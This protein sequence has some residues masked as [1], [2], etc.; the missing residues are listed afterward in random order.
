MLHAVTSFPFYNSYVYLPPK[1]APIPPEIVSNPKFFPY[2]KNVQGALDGVH[3]KCCPSAIERALARNRKGE[4]TQNCLAVC[5]FDL[6]FYYILAGWDGR[7]TDTTVY[8]DAHTSSFPIPPGRQYLA[9]G[10][11]GICDEL[12]IPYRK[13]RYH[14]AEWGC[15]DV[16]YV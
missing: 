14:L 15:A 9:D 4:V 3:V 12:L 11:Y 6:T 16:R 1:D 13:V 10:G 5:G 7:A 8:Y 2:F